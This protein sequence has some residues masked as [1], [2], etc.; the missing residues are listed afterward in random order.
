MVQSY[1]SWWVYCD[2]LFAFGIMVKELTRL[3]CRT[4][5]HCE[6]HIPWFNSYRF[7]SHQ[8]ENMLGSIGVSMRLMFSSHGEK[9]RL[10]NIQIWIF[11]QKDLMDDHPKPQRQAQDRTMESSRIGVPWA[12]SGSFCV[13]MMMFG[14]IMGLGLGVL[15][16]HLKH[17]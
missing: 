9:K 8:N 11:H 14:D 15:L 10:P 16:L 1:T 13:K 17:L 12:K 6:A 3:H 4:G 2:V 5:N 7:P